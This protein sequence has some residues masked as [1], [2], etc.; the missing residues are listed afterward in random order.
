MILPCTHSLAPA[1]VRKPLLQRRRALLLASFLL[2]CFAVF[3]VRLAV[4]YQAIA[5][6][7]SI[8]AW[9]L[10]KVTTTQSSEFFLVSLS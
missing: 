6:N 7:Q 3:S 1:A 2:A 8:N 4:F 5:F 10:S 9:D